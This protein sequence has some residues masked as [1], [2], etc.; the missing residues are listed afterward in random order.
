MPIF[1]MEKFIFYK[2]IYCII[3]TD[4]FH[5]NLKSYQNDSFIV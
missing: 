3:Y 1:T 5:L 2:N 4:Y